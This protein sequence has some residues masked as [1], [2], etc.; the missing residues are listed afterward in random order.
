MQAYRQGK[1]SRESSDTLK[2]KPHLWARARE[3]QE[4]KETHTNSGWP[5]GTLTLL[6][7]KETTGVTG[8]N[9]TVPWK[10]RV[11]D[12][13]EDGQGDMYFAECAGVKFTLRFGFRVGAG[14]HSRSWYLVA[15]VS[16]ADLR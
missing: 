1:R 7:P 3:R 5:T 11:R 8:E 14:P 6:S 15:S 2:T 16:S 4:K 13:G 10:R 12:G 9:T